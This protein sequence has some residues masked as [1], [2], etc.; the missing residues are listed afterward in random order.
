MFYEPQNLDRE[1]RYKIRLCKENSMIENIKYMNKLK[2]RS[3]KN[4]KILYIIKIIEKNIR[5]RWILKKFMYKIRL[6]IFKNMVS[7]NNV[8]MYYNNFEEDD[9]LLIYNN[10][11]KWTFTL[12]D[13]KN[14]MRTNLLKSTDMLEMV[15]LMPK[16]P[17]NQCIFGIGELSVIY[18]YFKKKQTRL[19]LIVELFR[20]AKN[21]IDEFYY[22]NYG[23]IVNM[24][25]SE[26][27]NNIDNIYL[28]GIFI[29]LINE[30]CRYGDIID[31]VNIDRLH[32]DMEIYK[33]DI[34][35]IIVK[36]RRVSRLDNFDKYMI[37]RK[38]FIEHPLLLKKR[39]VIIEEEEISE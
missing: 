1:S 26:N 24:I 20:N 31:N 15:V 29:S 21:D 13:I 37:L 16:N 7:V 36:L 3:V 39:R 19:P 33:G 32:R 18:D 10:K 2:N 17:Y 34:K 28:Y 11:K 38:F 6:K 25:V 35:S 12:N 30:Y 27:I 23:Y 14:I 8:D 22:I 9:M 4:V 5:L